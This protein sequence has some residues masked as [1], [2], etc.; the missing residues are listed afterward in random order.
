MA[1][2]PKAPESASTRIVEF[3]DVCK[4]WN[5]GTAL[6][7][8]ALK[9]LSFVIE[10][11]PGKVEFITIVGPSGCGKSTALGLLAG[12]QGVYPP[13]S[14]EIL[15]RGQPVSGPGKDRGMIFQKYSSFPHMTVLKNVRFGLEL[16]REELGLSHAEIDRQ[17]REWIAKVGLGGHERKYPHQLSGGQQQR[18]AI[19]RSLA[20][21]PEILLMDE[22]F[23]ALDEPT[24]FEMQRLVV[25]LYRN[26][27]ATVLMVTH[28]LA[29]AVYLGDRV[30]IFSQ[31]PGRIKKAFTGIFFT[32]PAGSPEEVQKSRA[33]LDV[34]EQVGAAFQAD[35]APAH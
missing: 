19:A 7:F 26:V 30:W 23:S 28:S 31:A 3:K 12:F 18:V 20:L 27:E 25:E 32:D 34:L 17:A 24:R 14:G 13:T 4:I 11:I 2:E 16:N 9:D 35:E 33:F 8:T 10:D 29:E 15:V 21:K 6:A 5:P 22:P 1:A